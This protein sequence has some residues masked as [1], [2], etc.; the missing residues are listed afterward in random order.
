MK[1]IT[2]KARPRTKEK[3]TFKLLAPIGICTMWVIIT[4]ILNYLG[5]N[6]SEQIAFTASFLTASIAILTRKRTEPPYLR[7]TPLLGQHFPLTHIELSMKVENLRESVAKDIEVRCK[8]VPNS[9]QMPATLLCIENEGIFKHQLAI[10]NAD[11]PITF[12][13][14]KVVDRNALLSQKFVYEISF[15]DRHGK[16]HRQKEEEIPLAERIIEM[17]KKVQ[18]EKF[19]A[20]RLFIQNHK[21]PNNEKQIEQFSILFKQLLTW[22]F[23]VT[24]KCRKKKGS[25][26]S[27]DAIY[28][29]GGSYLRAAS[30]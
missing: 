24:P 5:A 28:K 27:S 15:F 6:L 26:K 14:S 13:V 10:T 4:L 2:V 23:V 11:P 1:G 18:Q 9:S 17:E 19:P 12:L 25:K 7:I 8:L 22:D 30:H 3:T 29:G 21:N 16:K 20:H